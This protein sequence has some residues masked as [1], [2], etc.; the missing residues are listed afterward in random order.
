M[1]YLRIVCAVLVLVA[2]TA[3]A[4][5][6]AENGKA[7]PGSTLHAMGFGEARAMSDQD[8]LA[9]R[10]KGSRVIVFGTAFGVRTGRHFAAGFGITVGSGGAV[11]GGGAFGAAR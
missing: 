5:S 1:S 3:A 4:S 6:A 7:V 10:G 8:G 9:V 2:C 11:A